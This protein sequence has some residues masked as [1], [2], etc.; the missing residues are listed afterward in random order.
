M[1]SIL[2]A[3]LTFETYFIEDK[4]GSSNTEYHFAFK[5]KN[6]GNNN[7]KITDKFSS[8][9]CTVASLEKDIYAPNESGK[10]VGVFHIG[11]KTGIQENE[12]FLQTDNLGQS[13]IKLV[14]KIHIEKLVEIKPSLVV[15]NKGDAPNAKFISL[16]LSDSEKA[17]II[18]IEST[19]ENFIANRETDSNSEKKFRLKILPKSTNESVRGMIKLK[20]KPEDKVEKTFFIHTVIK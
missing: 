19:S 17:K 5:F 3:E 6:T 8:C 15:W 11:N 10:I 1:T 7:I 9:T 13:K 4:I 2:R 14:L 20:I 18:S 16:K 12:I